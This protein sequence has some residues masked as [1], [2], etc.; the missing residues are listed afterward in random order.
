MIDHDGE[1]PPKYPWVPIEFNPEC[2]CGY[3]LRDNGGD[4][5]QRMRWYCSMDHF[6]D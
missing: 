5:V 6:L 4:D 3:Y 2:G 1:G